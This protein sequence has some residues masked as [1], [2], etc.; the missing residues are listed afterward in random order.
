MSPHL[1]E[2]NMAFDDEVSRPTVAADHI[3]WCPGYMQGW[4]LLKLFVLSML[5]ESPQ[6]HLVE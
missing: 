4:I 5:A 1:M 6:S 2:V 3:D